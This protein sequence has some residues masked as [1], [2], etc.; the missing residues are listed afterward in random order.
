MSK[1]KRPSFQFYPNDWLGDMALQSCSLQAIGLWIN[2]CCRM[3][4]SPRYGYLLLQ[5]NQH[6]IAI[7]GLPLARLAMRSLEEIEPLLDE[8]LESG[9][10]KI[11]QKTGAY[12]SER[13]VKDERLRALRAAAGAEGGKTTASKLAAAKLPAN[14]HQMVEDEEG[15]KKLI[16]EKVDSAVFWE[17]YGRKV[18]KKKTMNKWAGMTV[19]TKILIFAHL[20]KYIAVTHIDGT[21]PSRKDPYTYLNSEIWLDE[22]LPGHKQPNTKA[23]DKQDHSESL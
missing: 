4:D 7:K 2:L 18:G 16:K 11:E 6:Q 20:P 23:D 21:F 13:M 8:L 19:A 14:Y 22:E 15:V 9:A 12:Y 10:M 17:V 5:Q 1:T 3:H